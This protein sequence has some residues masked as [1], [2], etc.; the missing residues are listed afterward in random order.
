MMSRIRLPLLLTLLAALLVLLLSINWAAEPDSPGSFLALA[1]AF[2]FPAGL[3]MVIWSTTTSEDTDGAPGL[4]TLALAVALIGYGMS[5]FGFHFGGV[6]SRTEIEGLQHLSRFFSLAR[7]Q[8]SPQWGIVGLDGFFVADADT[9]REALQLFVS[10]LPLVTAVVIIV[11]SALPRTTPPLAQ[12]VIGLTISAVTFPLAGHWVSGGGWLAQLG[13][14]LSMGHGLV[15]FAGVATIFIVGGGTVLSA[16]LVFGERPLSRIAAPPDPVATTP[17]NTFP[18]LASL[19]ALLSAI[20]WIALT[21]ANPLLAEAGETLHWPFTA[22]NGLAGFAGGALVAQLCSLFT[23]GRFDPLMGARGAV[24]GLIAASAGAP[25]LP[26]WAALATGAVAGLLVPLAVY[27]IERFSRLVDAAAAIAGYGLP[28][29]WGIISVALFA[30]GR[31]GQGW[32]GGSPADRGVAGLIITSG[33]PA[34]SGQLGAQVWGGI[35]LFALG[36]MVPW[37]VIRWVTGLLNLRKTQVAP[38]EHASANPSSS[39]GEL[40]SAPRS[41]DRVVDINDGR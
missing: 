6:A 2:L 13:H 4:V 8:T 24:A 17:R 19:G 7:G 37:G 26:T 3:T 31:W 12:L 11:F 27:G 29:L 25:F 14:T 41:L 30:S 22:L 39:P 36:F 5:G 15:D 10:Q 1:L 21:L 23:S 35:A 9:T 40:E 33:L 18:L 28:G 16:S 38:K 32:N 20:G 34:D